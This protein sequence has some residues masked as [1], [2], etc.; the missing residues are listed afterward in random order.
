[1]I[2]LVDSDIQVHLDNIPP[3]VHIMRMAKSRED[4]IRPYLFHVAKIVEGA[5]NADYDKVVAYVEQLRTRLEADGENEAANRL[6]QILGR[7]KVQKLGLSRTGNGAAH[8]APPVD[9]ESRLST[10]DE[11]FIAADAA[12]IVLS[13]E[14][15]TTVERFIAHFRA[16]D[17]LIAHGVGISASMLMYGP[18][19]CGKTL[20][21]RHIASELSLP[22]ITARSDGL[23]SSYLG[24][25]AKNIRMLFE[26][27]ASRP[28][29]LFLDEF[30]AVAKLR[31]D[32]RELGEL[33]R[34][35]ISLLQNIDALGSDHVL[36][37]ATNHEHLLDPA[38]WRRFAYKV[39]LDL[40]AF[41]SRV[42]MT[43][44]F[45][46]EF[47]PEEDADLVAAASEGLSG[48]HLQQIA[49]D[50][51]RAAV[52]RDEPQVSLRDTI[53]TILHASSNQAIDGSMDQQLNML[54]SLDSK[55]F[56]QS[57]LAGIFGISQSKVSKLL[58][59]I[60]S[61]VE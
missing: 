2:P 50:A 1:M 55:R 43:K 36:L 15:R 17:R 22:L 14:N 18:P 40:P 20:L 32:S 58:K 48:S 52:L 19:G 30:D 42:E 34:V 57:R 33:K 3:G 25:T 49:S 13:P 11:E 23:I 59:D 38:V 60:T 35:V 6:Q 51:I 61:H 56:T 47:L 53:I 37:A 39:R 4:T 26:H 54:R 9:S 8:P 44:R 7:S 45:Y 29:V 31:D 46:R 21:A 12:P 5:A 16:A 24:S 41:D 27:A 28:C 10:A